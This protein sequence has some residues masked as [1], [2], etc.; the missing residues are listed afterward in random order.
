MFTGFATRSLWTHVLA[1]GLLVSSAAAQ[2]PLPK[3]GEDWAEQMFSERSHDFGSVA[4]GADVRHKIQ[5]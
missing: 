4:R 2:E 5:V 3:A 1:A